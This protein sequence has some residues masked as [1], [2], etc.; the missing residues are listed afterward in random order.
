ME[1]QI[2]DRGG[3]GAVEKKMQGRWVWGW[4]SEGSLADDDYK[5]SVQ[6]PACEQNADHAAVRCYKFTYMYV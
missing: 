6:S 4:E 5:V 2:R 3:G 1:G